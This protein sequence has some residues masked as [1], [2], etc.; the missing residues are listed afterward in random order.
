MRN[1]SSNVMPFEQNAEFFG[2]RAFKNRKAGH[3]REAASLLL[4]A[5][6]LD[7][8]QAERRMELAEVYSEMGSPL[9]S[10]RVLAELLAH[11]N[12]DPAAWFGMACNLYAVGNTEGAQ[13][14]ALRYAQVAPEG[15]Y[16]EEAAELVSALQYAEHMTE[17][18]ERRLL[19]CH[20]LNSRAAALINADLPKR[21][22]P[23]IRK[24]LSISDVPATQSLYAFALSEAGETARALTEVNLL[25]LRHGLQTADCLYALKVL[26]VCDRQRALDLA[27]T[28]QSRSLDSYEKRQLLDT[29]LTL[30][31]GNIEPLLRSALTDSPNDRRL[32]LARA[33]L[34]YNAGHIDDALNDWHALLTVDPLDE[35]AALYIDAVSKGNAPA[36]PIPLTV[37][38][39]PDLTETVRGHIEAGT[40]NDVHLRWALLSGDQSA[41]AAI[42]ILQQQGD[43]KAVTL[44]R[45]ALVEPSVPYALK[46]HVVDALGALSAPRPYVIVSRASLITD[47]AEPR[48]NA[49][50]D[51][52]MPRAM[53]QLISLTAD[54]DDRLTVPLI[55]LWANRDALPHHEATLLGLGAAVLIEATLALG[56]PD[57]TPLIRQRFHLSGRAI[58][59]Y[60]SLLKKLT[61]K[62]D[63]HETD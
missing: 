2:R 17:P 6:Q 22:L 32:W 52:C 37:D 34:S 38:L 48:V 39:A 29:L 55:H 10:N 11:P 44:L 27:D 49:S 18:A 56:L 45:H 58:A 62:D 5:I 30:G 25:L 20:R 14:A 33:A 19:R 26:A 53:R 61:R 31:A 51:G 4:R 1:P 16:T 24:S 40:A 35:L 21:A 15:E 23:L 3:Y 42:K 9:E 41:H 8:D 59:Y 43:Q 47:A 54:I 63:L 13:I 7:P 60:T 12:A 46:L 50:Q 36:R 28:L 57:P